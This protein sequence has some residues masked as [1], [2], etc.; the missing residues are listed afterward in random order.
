MPKPASNWLFGKNHSKKREVC[1]CCEPRIVVSPNRVVVGGARH[2]PFQLKPSAK[3]G[4]QYAGPISV[5]FRLRHHRSI[6]KVDVCM[7]QN[8]CVVLCCIHGVQI[9]CDFVSRFG[10]VPTLVS[11]QQSLGWHGRRFARCITS[12]LKHNN[13]KLHPVKSLHLSCFGC[14]IVNSIVQ[15]VRMLKTTNQMQNIGKNML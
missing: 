10:T 2:V 4:F 1:Q 7:R 3:H 13:V 6:L 11:E 14:G 9:V 8:T 15:Y 5:D 12:I